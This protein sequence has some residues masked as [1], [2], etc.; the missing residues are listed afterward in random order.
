MGETKRDG[1]L[2][3]LWEILHVASAQEVSLL[4][5]CAITRLVSVIFLFCTLLHDYIFSN[6]SLLKEVLIF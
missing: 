5:A 3:F 6:V 2:T 1:L 4:L